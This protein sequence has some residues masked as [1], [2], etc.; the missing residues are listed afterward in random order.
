MQLVY[1]KHGQLVE[2]HAV[3]NIRGKTYIKPV[4]LPHMRRAEF[5]Y[6][7]I[8]RHEGGRVEFE[9]SHICERHYGFVWIF[10]EV[11]RRYEE[12]Y[13]NPWTGET[14]GRKA[15]RPEFEDE[16]LDWSEV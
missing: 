2:E 13:H 16:R 5:S 1:D 15:I 6:P 11:R 4:R 8:W 10:K 7:E 12:W 3:D 9:C 14:W